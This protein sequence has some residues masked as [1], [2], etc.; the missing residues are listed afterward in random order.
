MESMEDRSLA[1][2]SD[3]MLKPEHCGSCRA[4]LFKAADGAIAGAIQ[5]KCRRCGAYNSLRPS[6]PQP[7]ATERR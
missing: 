2:R 1:C 5:I 7:T 3:L 4:L 6:S